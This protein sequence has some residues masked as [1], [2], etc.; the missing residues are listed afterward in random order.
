M[1]TGTASWDGGPRKGERLVKSVLQIRLLAL[2]L[3]VQRTLCVDVRL[4][5]REELCEEACGQP[6]CAAAVFG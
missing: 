3:G 2:E 4:E 1:G 6:I 5:S